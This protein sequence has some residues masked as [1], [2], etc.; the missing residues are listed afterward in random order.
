MLFFSMKNNSIEWDAMLPFHPY[1]TNN[2]SGSGRL[3][4]TI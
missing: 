1:P 4:N 3:N 2:T